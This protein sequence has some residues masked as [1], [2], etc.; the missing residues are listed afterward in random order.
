MQNIFVFDIETVPDT[1][2]LRDT[3]RIENRELNL[4]DSEIAKAMI[5]LRRGETGSGFLRHHQHKIVA[6]S[7]L[8]RS[9]DKI[10]LWSL[11][12]EDSSEKEL[13]ERFFDGI[14]KYKPIL[15]SYNGSNFDLPVLQY[16]ALHHGVAAKTYLEVGDNLP[17]FKWNNY[18]NRYHSRHLDLMDVI[19][20][21]QS[22]A[23]ASLNAVSHLLSL[24]GKLGMDGSG[25]M[26]SYYSNDI[27]G[28]RSYCE[29]DVLNTYLIYLNFERIRGNLSQVEFEEE[30]NFTK[31]SLLETGSLHVKEYYDLIEAY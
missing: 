2:Q 12:E 11:G 16:R 19:S 29:I 15:V 17:D 3:Y 6:I 13:I 1:Q 26:D 5:A 27:E 10:K 31:K 21:Y 25:V 4:T 20:C 14:D 18:L 22:R 8:F 9:Q 23:V 7:V 24:T 30:L 28:I